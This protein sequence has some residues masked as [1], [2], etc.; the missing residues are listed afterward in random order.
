MS[1]KTI[2]TLTLMGASVVAS[3][4]SAGQKIPLSAAEAQCGKQAGKYA[5]TIEGR[6]GEQPDDYK[7]NDRYRS[8]VHAKSG[9]YPTNK[10]S[11][12]G[13]SISGS[14]SIGAVFGG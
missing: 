13:L 3:G 12:K 10:V 7:I 14:G 5:N 6:F 11:K 1:L 9:Q 8:C 4:C 2:A